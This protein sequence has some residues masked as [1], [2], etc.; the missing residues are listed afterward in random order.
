MPSGSKLKELHLPFAPSVAE[1]TATA[2]VE[3]H[4]ANMF[5]DRAR[6]TELLAVVQLAS[7]S[8]LQSVSWLRSDGDEPIEYTIERDSHGIPIEIKVLSATRF[9]EDPMTSGAQSSQTSS[10]SGLASVL[11]NVAS[12]TAF[13]AAVV[14]WFM[15]DSAALPFPV[16]SA[17][18][19]PA[20]LATG[21]A[22]GIASRVR[23]L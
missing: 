20:L 10:L 14:M 5:D 16:P 23:T 13:H 3:P 6:E 8:P 7:A 17:Y 1:G 22:L 15:S 19:T 21:V 18:A 9:E 4:K 11:A 2:S 12:N